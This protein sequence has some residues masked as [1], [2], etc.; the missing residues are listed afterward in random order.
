M[1]TVGAPDDAQGPLS[2]GTPE[3]QDPPDPQGDP[4]LNHI[5]H[6]VNPDRMN[7]EGITP[8]KGHRANIRI[9]TLNMRGRSSPLTGPGPISKWMAV[10]K[11]LRSR[12]I[13]ILA[14]QETHLSTDLATQ[15]EQL[16]S[17]RLALFNSPA[18]E[19]PSGSAGV[20]FV[21][22]K[23][24]LD[25]DNVTTTTLIPGRAIFI[26]VPRKHGDPLHLINIY[27]LNDLTQ[28]EPFWVKVVESWSASNLPHPHLMTGDFNLV[29]DPI[30]RT[31]ARS[32]NA[33][34]TAAL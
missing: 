11:A 31:P 2:G 21:I 18:L 4:P 9:A 33:S 26:T 29:E 27:A 8:S 32:D 3:P 34:A 1:P 20:T 12:Q 16:F 5:E 13:G 22:N 10:T 25:P 30:D 7:P 28:H 15:V 19:N 17:R 6:D 14:L 23:E 24:K